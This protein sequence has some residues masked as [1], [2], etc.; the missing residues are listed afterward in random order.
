[1]ARDRESSWAAPLRAPS[2]M[3][4]LGTLACLAASLSGRPG[5]ATALGVPTSLGAA[6]V[7]RRIARSREQTENSVWTWFFRAALAAA[8]GFLAELVIRGCVAGGAVAG[9]WE[10]TG[11]TIGA[12]G[13]WLLLHQGLVRWNRYSTAVSDP[14]DWLNGI[15]AVV[16]LAA[17]G[18]LVASHVGWM[19]SDLS[20][21]QRQGW[22]AQLAAL[23]VLL[24]TT[25][26]ISVIGNLQRDHRTWT[27]GGGLVLA[28]AV[29]AAA[30][31]LASRQTEADAVARILLGAMQV[32]W[33]VVVTAAALAALRRAGVLRPQ[34]ATSQPTTV[35]AVVVH[36]F[37]VGVLL[38]NGLDGGGDPTPAVL[39]ALAALGGGVRV[40][41]VVRD[42]AQL[43]MTRQEA[44]TDDLTGVPN[45]RALMEAV[46]AACQRPSGA[47]LLVIDLDR[48]NEVNDRFGHGIGDELIRLMARRLQRYVGNRGTLAR[49]GSDEFAL[50]LPGTDVHGA[51]AIAEDLLGVLRAP[52][53]VAGRHL[54]VSASIGIASTALTLPDQDELLRCA[55]A[56]M[57]AAKRAGGGVSVYDEEA[58]RWAREQHQLVEELRIV[59]GDSTDLSCGTVVVHYQPQVRAGSGEVVGAEALVRWQH[60]RLGL[61]DPGDFLDLAESHGLMAPLTWRVLDDALT[62]A[63]RWRQDGHDLRVAVN[64]STSCLA[65]PE[66]PE[67]IEASLT[68]HGL[69]PEQLVIEITETSL[70]R[71]PT[72][73][74]DVTRRIAST[75]VDISIDDYG[76]GYSSLAY[77]ND[78]PAV[79][80]KLDRSF[81][82]KLTTDA[83]TAAIVAGTVQLVHRLGLRLLAEGVEDPAT[84]EA[85]TVMGCDATQGYLHAR[86]APAAE[87]RSWLETV[88]SAASSAHPT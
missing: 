51:T 68:R 46:G 7:L 3:L 32:A 42:L 78:L 38:L 6:D 58:D 40:L 81:T 44:R 31:V 53:E 50:A 85:L 70:M 67:I 27:F 12:L 21:W 43:A 15:S 64:L 57:Y 77:L 30:M 34:D 54:W 72:M 19:A 25:M 74:I 60:P 61:L 62:E 48:F 75:G 17:F 71:D 13:S 47:V 84:L 63:A 14:A 1:M 87:F 56:A 80:L 18:N 88:V 16:A 59:L 37:S 4:C 8:L 28:L 35:G 36:L 2:L 26:T 52:A 45:R 79:E 11:L 10:G 39:A 83:R 29:E 49:L 23:V 41:R 69:P 82:A 76:T 55:D 66:L 65:D 86:P 5:L 20:W 22:I 73:A 9:A 33:L 24:G